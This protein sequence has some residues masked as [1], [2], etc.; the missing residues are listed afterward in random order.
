MARPTKQQRRTRRR[1]KKNRQ[2]KAKM[3]R[4]QKILEIA[5]TCPALDDF[6]ASLDTKEITRLIGIFCCP[7]EQYLCTERILREHG[8]PGYLCLKAEIQGDRTPCGD[9]KVRAWTS[10]VK[11]E[12][13]TDD[14]FKIVI[15]VVRQPPTGD[16]DSD[17]IDR[18]SEVISAVHELGHAEDMEKGINFRVGQA[19]DIANAEYYAHQFA[20]RLLQERNMVMGLVTYLSIAVCPMVRCESQSTSDAAK[21]FMESEEYRNYLRMIPK[22]LR[23]QFAMPDAPSTEENHKDH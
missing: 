16:S 13:E 22:G 7:P 4:L 14:K 19:F 20:C 12:C 6:I 15:G 8:H 17:T 11:R 1:N 21:R 23:R 10:A 2:E 18:W 5:H 3:R 9:T